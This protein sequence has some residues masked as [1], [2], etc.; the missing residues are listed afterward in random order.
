MREAGAQRLNHSSGPVDP[1]IADPP[2][3]LQ[4][5]GALRETRASVPPA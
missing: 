1:A 4:A 3:W 5:H 2:R